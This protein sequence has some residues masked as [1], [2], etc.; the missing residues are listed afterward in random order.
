[1]Q[2]T[3]FIPHGGGPCFFMDWNP[4]DAWDKMREFLEGILPSLPERPKAILVITAH[5]ETDV[6]TVSTN[7]KPGMH[8]DYYGFP[9]HTYEL[10]FP[11]KGDAGVAARAIELL[12][13]A[14]IETHSDDSYDFDHG[15]FVPLMVAMPEADIP[16]VPVSIRA[17]YDPEHHL[18]VGKALAPLREKNV[19]IVG[20]GMS[21]HNLRA[22]FARSE[23]PG[24]AE[25]DDWLTGALAAEP[26][27]RDA[28]LKEWEQ[29]PAA[30]IAH[31]EEDHLVPVFAVAGAAG[32]D[33]GVQVLKDHVMG[34]R[35][36]A[37]RFG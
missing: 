24:S 14:G 35:V 31:P 22:L 26:E 1:M 34:A 37:Y 19:L 15:V 7:P 10:Q 23:A 13:A 9:S 8:Y 5:W 11:A 33:R 32:A 28:A 4:P 21:Y 18:S 36:S 16:V 3:Y 20:S 17:D 27:A 30:R 12:Q 29:A 6:T 25:F 2:P